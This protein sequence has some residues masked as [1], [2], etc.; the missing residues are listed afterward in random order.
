MIPTLPPTPQSG[1]KGKDE[2]GEKSE[3]KINAS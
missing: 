3:E 2:N 1:I